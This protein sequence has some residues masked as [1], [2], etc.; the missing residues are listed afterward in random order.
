MQQD[1]EWEL[2]SRERDAHTIRCEAG[3]S[4][5]GLEEKVN[6]VSWAIFRTGCNSN[7]RMFAESRKEFVKMTA[8]LR[9]RSLWDPV[10]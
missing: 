7:L 4:V 8:N 2:G 9:G 1:R 5:I 3:I 6:A 10:S